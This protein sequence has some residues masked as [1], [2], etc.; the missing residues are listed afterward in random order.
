M[1]RINLY[2]FVLFIKLSLS[3]NCYDLKECESENVAFEDYA[4]DAEL[5]CLGLTFSDGEIQCMGVHSCQNAYLFNVSILSGYAPFSLS[6]TLVTNIHTNL[7]L[8]VPGY[9]AGYNLTIQ[10]FAGS[11]CTANCLANGCDYLTVTCDSS[12]ICN[13]NHSSID[14]SVMYSNNNFP[15]V[16]HGFDA[17]ERISSDEAIANSHNVRCDL[18]QE[19]AYIDNFTINYGLYCTA[20]SSC[21]FSTVYINITDTNTD[22]NDDTNNNTNI[23]IYCSGMLS[24]YNVTFI[25]DN[26]VNNNL[27]NDQSVT[28]ICGAYRSCDDATIIGVEKIYA[29]G[30]DSIRHT[31]IQSRPMY[32]SGIKRNNIMDVYVGNNGALDYGIGI[33]YCNQ[34][35]L[36]NVYCDTFG[37]CKNLVIHCYGSCNVFCNES[38][39]QDCPTVYQYNYSIPNYDTYTTTARF[40]MSTS[41]AGGNNDSA[42]EKSTTEVGSETKKGSGSWDEETIIVGIIVVILSIAC[43][44]LVVYTYIQWQQKKDKNARNTQN[45]KNVK[46]VKNDKQPHY[47]ENIVPDHPNGGVIINNDAIVHHVTQATDEDVDNVQNLADIEPEPQD[48]H[49][50]YLFL[51]QKYKIDDDHDGKQN[52]HVR[53]GSVQGSEGLVLQK[54][55]ENVDL[56]R[57]NSEGMEFES[58]SGSDTVGSDIF[59]N[60]SNN[61]KDTKGLNSPTTKPQRHHTK[62]INASNSSSLKSNVSDTKY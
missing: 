55:D 6:N 27:A 23:T 1:S 21:A 44:A 51:Q 58:D 32:Y 22:D 9:Q 15:I 28:L 20:V 45:E 56:N 31:N 10:C 4:C 29:L 33:I 3:Y 34:S 48:K 13:F 47:D 36:C 30:H 57:L 53:G 39:V 8:W 14:T 52:I 2:L 46:I 26:D 49:A 18:E 59:E 12:S 24:C 38:I 50:Y 62:K 7:E 11:T 17:L 42:N 25:V 35:D 60:T 61:Y 5:A 16:Y 43:T 19:C 41:M 40:A 37:A 54:V